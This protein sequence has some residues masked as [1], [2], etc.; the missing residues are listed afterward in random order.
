M[1]R[2][3]SLIAMLAFCTPALADDTPGAGGIFFRRGLVAQQTLQRAEYKADSKPEPKSEPAAAQVQQA[4][5]TDK[6]REV[7]SS[8]VIRRGDRVTRAGAG[9]MGVSEQLISDATS[10]PADDSHK[11]FLSIIVDDAQESQALLYDLKH[12]PALRAWANIDEQRDSWAHVTV[13]K[14]GDGTQEWRWKELR[15]T[16]LPVMILQPPAK[17]KDESKPD[18]WEWGNPK[19]VVWQWDGYDVTKPT[20]AQIRSDAIRTA[21]KLYCDKLSS[22]PQYARASSGPRAAAP[23]P[24][25]GAK[26]GADNP[27]PKQNDI[28]I[29]PPFNL[30][31]VPVAP[32]QAPVFPVDPTQ[33]V[34]QPRATTTA[35]EP[36]A[37]SLLLKILGETGG[38]TGLNNL[39]LLVIAG[40][41]VWRI[42]A[43]N[44][45]LK[46]ILG[47]DAF[48]ALVKFLNQMAGQQSQPTTSSNGQS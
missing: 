18:S 42:I 19:T 8:E 38:S 41:Q 12:S 23:P 47:D 6:P 48:G 26:Q 10:P 14:R 32:S 15:I 22:N 39:L 24:T 27:G 46:T 21:L 5:E 3:F 7:D 35:T 25:R 1:S 13:Y 28:G 11:W 9:P 4:T 37:V 20:R 29:N 40:L 33:V 44:L 16:K 31:A 43:T 17:L 30:P 45:H 2:L 34:A 36:S